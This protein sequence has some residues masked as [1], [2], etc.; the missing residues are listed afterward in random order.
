M[1]Y[2][3]IKEDDENVGSDAKGSD[4]DAEDAEEAG[5]VLRREGSCIQIVMK[6]S[7]VGLSWRHG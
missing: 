7:V 5:E 6:V 1:K 4:A 3:C 2:E